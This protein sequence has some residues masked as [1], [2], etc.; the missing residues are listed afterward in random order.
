MTGPRRARCTG[1]QAGERV[2]VS[3]SMGECV[4]EAVCVCA[5]AVSVGVSLC[6]VRVRHLPP[7]RGGAWVQPGHCPRGQLSEGPGS[8]GGT[9]FISVSDPQ[10]HPAPPRCGADLNSGPE[11]GLRQ[12]LQIVLI[13]QGHFNAPKEAESQ[14]KGPSSGESRP[15]GDARAA[16]DQE[17]LQGTW[18]S[19][20][21]VPP[22]DPL[23]LLSMAE[24]RHRRAPR[25]CPPSH[26]HKATARVPKKLSG[27]TF[28]V[29]QWWH[30][31]HLKGPPSQS[32]G[33]G[34]HW[35]P[36]ARL[37]S[38]GSEQ[39]EG[40]SWCAC[41]LSGPSAE[42]CTCP[43][44]HA[45]ARPAGRPFTDPGALESP[46][47]PGFRRTPGPCRSLV[48]V[49]CKLGTSQGSGQHIQGAGGWA[50]VVGGGVP[51]AGPGA[52]HP[53][54]AFL[55]RQWIQRLLAETGSSGLQPTCVQ[56]GG[57]DQPLSH[58]V[59]RFPHLCKRVSMFFEVQGQI[60]QGQ[61]QGEAIW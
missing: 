19:P 44:P 43:A 48:S 8:P 41:T 14:N 18:V 49:S 57:L 52:L 26:G 22:P 40:Q 54:V 34:L 36:E 31:G 20:T 9:R 51:H 38:G 4:S 1:T 30:L 59:P 55:P 46:V 37:G 33:E 16:A 47:T 10:Q 15:A 7:C 39:G 35:G 6:C 3:V 5:H 29:P 45:P 24:A 56:P 11:R 42:L 58:P 61:G 27:H 12:N 25:S 32:R 13:Q 2:R 50:E 23:P 53:P 60:L 28:T 21:V 17:A